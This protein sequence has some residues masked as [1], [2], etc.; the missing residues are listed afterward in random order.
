MTNKTLGN[1]LIATLA[2]TILTSVFEESMYVETSDL[3]YTIA[4]LSWMVFATWA[5]FRLRKE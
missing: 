4:G 3:L 1:I 5:G 2:L